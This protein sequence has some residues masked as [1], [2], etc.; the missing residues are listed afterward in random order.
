MEQEP[1]L[2]KTNGSNNSKRR[3]VSINSCHKA[4]DGTYVFIGRS[5]LHG[6]VR[7]TETKTNRLR[8]H[9]KPAHH[10]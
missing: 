6:P 3:I 5:Q 1:T 4:N 8:R 10:E 9:V 7:D 2:K